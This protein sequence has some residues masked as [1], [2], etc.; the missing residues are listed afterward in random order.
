MNILPNH[1]KKESAE[2]YYPGPAERKKEACFAGNTHS[3]KALKP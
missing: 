2:Q 3:G 1:I